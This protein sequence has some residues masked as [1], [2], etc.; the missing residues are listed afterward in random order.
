M[1]EFFIGWHQPR[2]GISGCGSFDRTMVSVN[3]LIDRRS[4]FPVKRWILDSGAF[5]RITSGKGH[6]SPWIYATQIDRWSRCGDLA[7]A[8]TQDWMCESFVLNI[9]GMTIADHQRLTIERFDILKKLIQ[10]GTY[11]MPVLQGYEPVD[12]VRHVKDYGDRLADGDWVGVGSICKRNANA[13]SIASVLL[14]IKTERPDLRLHGFGIKRTALESGLVWDL[15]YSA[16]SQ[17]AGLSS[18]SGSN[19]Y[20]GSN[21]PNIAAKYAKNIKPPLQLSIFN[22]C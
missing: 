4:D 11:L 12:Y 21:D 1:I 10:S 14:A 22:Q 6:L 9:T 3:R 2:N 15:L 8:V 7:A 17:A 13:I 16:D 20:A 5:T 18:G 19:K